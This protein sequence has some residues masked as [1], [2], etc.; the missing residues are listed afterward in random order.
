M[1]VSVR[2]RRWLA[3]RAISE[4]RVVAVLCSRRESGTQTE[5][6]AL[7]YRSIHDLQWVGG[8]GHRSLGRCGGEGGH[9]DARPSLKKDKVHKVAYLS[10][11][12]K[13]FLKSRPQYHR[14]ELELETM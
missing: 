9:P 5:N 12:P 14:L 13:K 3:G 7:S 1:L 8:V 11:N 2:T 6:G 4:S 10:T